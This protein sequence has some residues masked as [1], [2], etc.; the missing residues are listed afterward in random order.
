M[1]SC[2]YAAKPQSRH[3]SPGGRWPVRLWGYQGAKP[4]EWGG[5]GDEITQPLSVPGFAATKFVYGM[6]SELT[7]GYPFAIFAARPPGALSLSV[8]S[9]PSAVRFSAVSTGGEGRKFV[10][11]AV[12]RFRSCAS[13]QQ[14]RPP[15]SLCIVKLGSKILSSHAC[16]FSSLRQDQQ[17][18]N[19]CVNARTDTQLVSRIGEQPRPVG[20]SGGSRCGAPRCVN[21]YKGFSFLGFLS[22]P[23]V[24]CRFL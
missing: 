16:D 14:D 11:A 1:K 7:L 20:R 6:F 18:L 3:G 12:N 13:Y 15:V 22:R 9:V 24:T 8:L 4:L 21:G 10:C 23:D 2:T 19:Q 17:V 5:S